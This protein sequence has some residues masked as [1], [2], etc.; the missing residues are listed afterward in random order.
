MS[1]NFLISQINS[2]TTL[3]VGDIEVP[4]QNSITVSSLAQPNIRQRL[5]GL[6]SSNLSSFNL[7]TAFVGNNPSLAAGQS[8][9]VDRAINDL[10][11][12]N[13]ELKNAR[14]KEGVLNSIKRLTPQVKNTLFNKLCSSITPLIR[15]N[16]SVNESQ[17]VND[18]LSGISTSSLSLSQRTNFAN[19]M[20]NIIHKALVNNNVNATSV[21]NAAS[22]Q[23]FVASLQSFVTNEFN[24]MIGVNVVGV[25]G[26][27]IDTEIQSLTSAATSLQNNLV[28]SINALVN[29]A[30]TPPPSPQIVLTSLTG[31]PATAIQSLPLPPASMSVNSLTP[32]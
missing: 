11:L 26:I 13:I 9:A 29:P 22:L 20:G 18:I 16:N 23:S 24:A 19:V 15:N 21:T 25:S 6:L 10:Y 12:N 17:I 14:I 32:P 7:L 1:Y 27:S 8:S 4:V 5:R 2:L 3:P 28:N 31:L 30:I